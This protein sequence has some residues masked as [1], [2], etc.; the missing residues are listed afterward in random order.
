MEK[1]CTQYLPLRK[2]RHKQ[3]DKWGIIVPTPYPCLFVSPQ[4]FSTEALLLVV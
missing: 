3:S 4:D 2:V 1:Y